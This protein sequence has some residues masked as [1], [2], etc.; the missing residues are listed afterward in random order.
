[1]DFIK[2]TIIYNKK[3]ISQD[4][5]HIVFGID[6]DFIRPV[7]VLMT[8]ILLFNPDENIVF[9][10]IINTIDATSK[11][12][13]KIFS[14]KYNIL[15]YVYILNE[16]YFKELPTTSYINQSMYN[17]FLIPSLLKNITNKALYLDA[18]IIYLQSLG[19]LKYINLDNVIIGVVEETNKSVIKTQ[20]K[21][22]HLLSN[23]Y[24]NSG[25][26]YINI[27]NWIK[28]AINDK[29]IETIKKYP[30]LKFPDQDLLNIVLEYNCIYMDQKYN[31]TFDVRY[32]PNRYVYTI[33]ENTVFL[34]YVGR[35]KPWQEWCMHPLREKFREIAKKSLWKDFPWDKPK[36]YKQM[37]NMAKS[38]WIYHQKIKSIF[39]YL[40][41][42]I[43]KIKSKL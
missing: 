23:K 17:R 33:P 28:N 30:N 34:H 21:N 40:K 5:F 25:V 13:L 8:S 1:M 43:Y 20:I 11:N 12:K 3:P 19:N 39:W 7:S 18:D 16:N 31:Y 41:Y 37:K 9:H 35:F 14:L 42:S 4:S 15:I 27:D 29:L 22:L 2:D 32:K 10:I 36:T 6:N 38:Y 24:F 26:L